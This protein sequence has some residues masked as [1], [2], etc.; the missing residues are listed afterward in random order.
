MAQF[1]RD[2]THKIV[3][4]FTSALGALAISLSARAAKA[5]GLDVETVSGEILKREQLGCTGFGGG[6]AIP[7]ARFPNLKKPFGILVRLRKPLDYETID[8]EPVDIVF[9]LLIPAN[10]GDQLNA[11]A[12]IVRKLRDRS[13]LDRVRHASDGHAM[14]QAFI[15]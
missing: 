12:A 9:L 14:Y 10:S 13:T 8:G 4:V 11:L 2:Q 6:I 1:F 5:T 7:H 15:H 3:G